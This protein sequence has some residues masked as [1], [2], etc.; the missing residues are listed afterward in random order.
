MTA[1]SDDVRLWLQAP[2]SWQITHATL[3]RDPDARGFS[4]TR[5][6]YP[7]PRAQSPKPIWLLASNLPCA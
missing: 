2:G 3:H 4:V 7:K 5:V 6:I 1:G